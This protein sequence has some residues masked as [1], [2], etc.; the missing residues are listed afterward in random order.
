MTY[1]VYIALLVKNEEMKNWVIMN[2]FLTSI[3]ACYLSVHFETTIGEPLRKLSISG[4]ILWCMGKVYATFFLLGKLLV[5][6]ER[7]EISVVELSEALLIGE[8][9]GVGLLNLDGRGGGHQKC[10]GEGKLH[11]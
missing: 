6:G 9:G 11:L 5:G 2:L 10:G 8:K 7:L 3:M 1:F 4:G